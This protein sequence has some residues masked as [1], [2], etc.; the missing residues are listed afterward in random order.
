MPREPVVIVG[1]ATQ[2]PGGYRGLAEILGE[3]SGSEA[4]VAGV[5]PLDWLAGY[6]RGFGQLVFEVAS[7]VDRALLGSE[8]KK[9]VLVGHSAGGLACRVF[10]GGDAPYGGRRYSGHR[11]VSGLI[12]PRTPPPTPPPG[13]PSGPL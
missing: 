9:V 5:T 3:T 4:H 8:A 11:R 12:T 10:I 7:A 13:P 2:W 1:G 6:Y